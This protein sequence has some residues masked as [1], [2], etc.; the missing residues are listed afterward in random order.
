MLERGHLLVVEPRQAP[1][2]IECRGRRRVRV[3]G[4]LER[5]R[6]R[7]RVR[8]GRDGAE[9]GDEQHLRQ[10]GVERRRLGRGE[11]LV[12]R[13][14][15]CLERVDRRVDVGVRGQHAGTAADPEHVVGRASRSRD[16]GDV[17]A[18]GERALAPVDGEH[19]PALPREAAAELRQQALDAVGVGPARRGR[20]QARGTRVRGRPARAAW[21]YD[22]FPVSPQVTRPW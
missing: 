20:P 22:S 10:V 13:A 12:E 7:L 15:G 6:R 8:G 21:P 4:E 16:R 14:T 1:E 3:G 2:A 18:V 9:P 5:D 19:A 11:P 17:G